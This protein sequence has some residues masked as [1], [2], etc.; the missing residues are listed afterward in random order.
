M[1]QA[2]AADDFAAC[3]DGA[4]IA[5]LE[6]DPA[7]AVS[8]NRPVHCGIV[9]QRLVH[10]SHATPDIRVAILWAQVP[11]SSTWLVHSSRLSAQLP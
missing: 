8:E 11:V 2:H 3:L 1:G 9:Q 7:Q 5:P 4:G 10:G 6:I